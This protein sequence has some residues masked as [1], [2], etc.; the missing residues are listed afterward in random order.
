MT[1]KS[2]YLYYLGLAATLSFGFAFFV[3][4]LAV[5]K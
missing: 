1:E 5:T 2:A 4:F 3:F